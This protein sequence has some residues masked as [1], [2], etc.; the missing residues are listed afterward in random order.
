MVLLILLL[1]L[2]P[3]TAY[4]ATY[5]VAATG[6]N[7]SRSCSTAQNIS[8]PKQTIGSGQG[9]TGPGDTLIL[10]SGTYDERLQDGWN[11]GSAT[12]S[13]RITVKGQDG[14]TVIWRAPST[15]NTE[16]LYLSG[17]TQHHL[18]FQNIIFDGK[19]K[20]TRL[21]A[22]TGNC[23][24][25]DN[26][27]CAHH[28][29][30]I[31][32]E[33]RNASDE[34]TVS[35]THHNIFLGGSIHDNDDTTGLRHGI[36]LASYASDNI[37]DGMQIYNNQG[38]GIHMYNG[39]AA[40]SDRNIV[41]NNTIYDNALCC[42]QSNVILSGTDATQFYN[43]V[44]RGGA[45]GVAVGYAAGSTNVVV[46]NNTI[47]GTGSARP[48]LWI[49]GTNTIV[50]NNIVYNN[51][52]GD[53]VGNGSTTSGSNLV[54]I[55]PQFADMTNA[56]FRLNSGSPALN[57]AENL[58]SVFTT[59]ITGATRVV[60]WDIGAYDM[61]ASGTPGLTPL[62]GIFFISPSGTNTTD[63]A[64]ATGT[65]G[66]PSSNPFGTYATAALCMLKG[67]TLYMRG[68]V[69]PPLKTTT[70]PFSGGDNWSAPTTIVGYPG[71]TI[72]LRPT[73]G[74]TTLEL[75]NAP[76]DHFLWIKDINVDCNSVAFS[77]GIALYGVND[78]KLEGVNAHHCHFEGVYLDSTQGVELRGVQV[79]DPIT[80]NPAIGISG[81][82]NTVVT[83][84]T[85]YGGLG[86]GVGSYS[87][88]TGLVIEKNTVRNNVG[89]GI[90]VG[91]GT[92][93]KVWNNIVQQNGIGVH[94][95][96]NENGAQVY[97][98]TIWGSTGNC[99]VIEGGVS[100]QVSNNI[101]NQQ[102]GIVNNAGAS[103]VF[104]SNS[105]TG[106]SGC[107]TAS[108]LFTS[109]VP[110][111]AGFLHL[112]V[113]SPARDSGVVIPALTQ[114]ITGRSRPTGTGVD[115]PDRGVYEEIYQAAGGGGIPAPAVVQPGRTSMHLVGW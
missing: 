42:G 96:A 65:V 114:D 17:S 71:E 1:L 14:E 75:S 4:S 92:G 48:G 30:F 24:T 15:G 97:Y 73:T 11:S 101:C 90:G 108:P 56:D 89:D 93:L 107:D 68:G 87:G 39:E 5:Y 83:E 33:F 3:L 61:A 70:T 12:E 36:Y 100:A 49:Q 69:Y 95:L 104:A 79:H 59:D 86:A 55:D 28:I 105:C 57:A 103:V 35:R 58:S 34:I 77:A 7:D 47:V 82:T 106:V 112:A 80:T 25:T 94:I 50:K 8:T 64:A 13:T 63:C 78:I 109:I 99:I 16:A 46:Y 76:T 52:G 44:V 115:K 6:G 19:S 41:R 85:I 43:N 23:N 18:T 62:M 60:P 27:S 88:N 72:T 51:A 53:F 111:Q 45:S 20:T 22:V 26:T 2:Y 32:C 91:G 21:P 40:F 37:I 81:T 54:G 9:C 74:V 102:A 66:S 113:G 10:R 84:S 38:Y 31:N 67:S 110:G 29:T 98:N